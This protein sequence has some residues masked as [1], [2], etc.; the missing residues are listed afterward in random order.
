MSA[1]CDDVAAGIVCRVCK[2][3][4]PA[5]KVQAEVCDDCRVF[6]AS[7]GG[8]IPRNRN[9]SGEV[10]H[11]RSAAENE[12][13]RAY[14]KLYYQK[15]KDRVLAQRAFRYELQGDEAREYQREYQRR[16]YWEKK[17]KAATNG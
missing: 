3:I 9:R 14:A 5:E 2:R 12:R 7:T 16:T 10:H 13:R 1:Y 15:N 17:Q 6:A 8:R 11:V 4:L